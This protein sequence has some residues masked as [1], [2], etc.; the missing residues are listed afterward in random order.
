AYRI[1]LI[2]EIAPLDQ[3]RGRANEIAALICENGPM[4]VRMTKEMTLRGLDMSLIDGL[5]LYSEYSR[6]VFQSEDMIEGTRS[7]AEKRK[8]VFKGR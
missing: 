3:V 4:A 8:P 2:Q 6:Q 5:R 7:F 1:G